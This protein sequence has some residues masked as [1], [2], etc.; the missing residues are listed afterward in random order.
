[1]ENAIEVTNQAVNPSAAQSTTH[2]VDIRN[3]NANVITEDS[4]TFDEVFE[5]DG[6]NLSG[7]DAH[8]LVQNYF[9]IKKINFED[10]VIKIDIDRIPMTLSNMLYLFSILFEEDDELIGTTEKCCRNIRI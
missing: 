2:S 4:S 8:Q 6:Y 10:R 9:N 1:M 3:M 5:V 7:F